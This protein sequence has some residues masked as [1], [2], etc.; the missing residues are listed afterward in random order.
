[1]T[2]TDYAEAMRAELARLD[3]AGDWRVRLDPTNGYM[4]QEL[5]QF[6]VTLASP[7]GSVRTSLWVRRKW[8]PVP[9]AMARLAYE[10]ITGHY[11]K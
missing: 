10:K 9:E 7:C 1:M 6:F 2:S 3:P 8:Q 11:T 5:H 4:P